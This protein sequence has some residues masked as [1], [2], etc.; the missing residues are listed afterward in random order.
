MLFY[1]LG[2]Q[3]FTKCWSIEIT[4]ILGAKV[5]GLPH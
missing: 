2:Q 3:V 5:L 1:E 4:K